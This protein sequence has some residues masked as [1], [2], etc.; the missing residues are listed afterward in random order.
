V[1]DF[2]AVRGGSATELPII[3]HILDRRT[4]LTRTSLAKRGARQTLV[5]N[6]DVVGVVAA[7]AHRDSDDFAARRS[8]QPRRIERYLTAIEKGGASPLVVLNKSDLDPEA[9]GTRK[10]LADRLGSCPVITLSCITNPGLEPLLERT[11][12]GQTI[13][14]VG[15]SGVG[16]SSIVNRLLGH[17]AQKVSSERTSD[18]RGRHTTTHRELFRTESGV[19]VIDTPGMREFALVGGDEADLGAF[20]DITGLAENCQFRDCSHGDEPGCAVAEAVRNGGIDADRLRSFR[21]LADELRQADQARQRR[22][23]DR[24]KRR[25]PSSKRRRN[26]WDDGK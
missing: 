26:D 1:G 19:I 16:K 20:S 3:E 4:W 7:F 10:A 25:F 8:L 2:V 17:E 5:A 23:P 24:G 14:L 9:E 6:V 21:L 13:G 11:R 15:L 12:A 22:K 18:A